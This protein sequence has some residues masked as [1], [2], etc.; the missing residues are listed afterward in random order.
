[1]ARTGEGGGYGARRDA[2]PV[3]EAGADLSRD[4]H[5]RSKS[6]R[7]QGGSGHTQKRVVQ[8]KGLHAAGAA[9]QR[10]GTGAGI[11][12]SSLSGR[13]TVQDAS[14]ASDGARTLPVQVDPN[15]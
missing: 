12:P 15:S 13:I 10:H 8:R 3:P 2:Y 6:D 4:Q 11:K 5:R 7:R 9:E 1:M 14:A